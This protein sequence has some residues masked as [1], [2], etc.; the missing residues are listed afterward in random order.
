[1]QRRFLSIVLALV[2]LA[3]VIV[4]TALM[5]RPLAASRL[6]KAMEPEASPGAPPPRKVLVSPLAGTWYEANPE[7]LGK[8]LDGY[9]ANATKTLG[10]DAQA[11]MGDGSASVHA[12]ILPHAGYRYSGQTAAYGAATLR[13]KTF[14][15]VIVMGPSHR[16]RMENAASVSDATHYKTPLGEVPLDVDFVTALKGHRLFSTVSATDEVE[17]S[18]QIQVPLLQRALG[19]FRL[20]PIVIGEIDAETADQMAKI[21]CGLVDEKTLVIASSDFTHYG[22]TFGYVPFRDDVAANLEKLDMGAYEYIA[23]KNADGFADYVKETGATICGEAPIRV[24]LEMLPPDSSVHMLKYD[25]SGRITGDYRNSVSYLSI[26]FRGQWQK[27]TPSMEKNPHP[28]TLS[29]TDKRQL[30]KLA[31]QTLVYFMTHKRRP[32]PEELGIEVTPGMKQLMGAF[33]T[34]HKYG[35]LRGCIGTIEPS[36]P[37]YQ[38]VMEYVLHAAFD[39]NRFPPVEAS[40]VPDLHI[41]ISAYSEGPRPVASYRDIVIGKHGIVLQK[42]N[43]RALFLPQVAPEQGWDIEETL[44]H[45]SMKAGLPSDAW[46]E[47]ASFSVFEAI[48]FGE[49]KA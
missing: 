12:L 23:A 19:N 43:R 39:D 17:H 5:R 41:E 31:R 15:R 28:A 24:L 44:R 8:E 20:V 10:K 9:L 37:I 7:A 6:G 33:V 16:V 27:G 30:L 21:L 35:E 4:L 29:E 3:V 45:L 49:E 18:V 2:V 42:G 13:G 40:E 38:V 11:T 46:K 48:V 22:P 34:L 32:E 26:G 1:M 47:G 36:R 25:T 14:S